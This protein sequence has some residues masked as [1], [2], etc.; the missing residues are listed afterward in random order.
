MS[1]PQSGPSRVGWFVRL[2]RVE[3]GLSQSAAADAAG[4]HRNIWSNIEKAT[5]TKQLD[6]TRAAV[7]RV[8]DWAP[9]SFD[10]IHDGAE[11]TPRTAPPATIEDKLRAVIVAAE[12]PAID[13]GDEDIR[14]LI[15]KKATDELARLR[16]TEPDNRAL[17]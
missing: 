3:K 9:G 7:E 4:I 11:P 12:D 10:A 13:W 15:I 2:R 16:G 8:L 5:G 1:A 6:I 17:G 14:R